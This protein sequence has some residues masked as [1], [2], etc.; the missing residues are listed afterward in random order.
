MW[1][2]LGLEVFPWSNSDSVLVLV[3]LVSNPVVSVGFKFCGFGM[4]SGNRILATTVA[5]KLSILNVMKRR[6]AFANRHVY[7]L[8]LFTET[9]RLSADAISQ[10]LLRDEHVSAG[11]SADYHINACYHGF[12][13]NKRR[14][15]AHHFCSCVQTQC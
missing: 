8:F 12:G 9:G 2:R 14:Q 6:R 15:V 11:S 4:V 5:H 13:W 3:I 7:L 1:S 10:C